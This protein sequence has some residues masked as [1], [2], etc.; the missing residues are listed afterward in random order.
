MSLT[1]LLTSAP[2]TG[3]KNPDAVLA[4]IPKSLKKLGRLARRYVPLVKPEATEE[5]AIAHDYLTQ[6]GGAERVVLAMHRAFPDAPIYTTLY[7]PEGTFPEFKD[8][9]IITS[10]LNKIG[11]LR[12]NHRMALPILPFA[13]SFLKV[14]AERAVVSTTGWAHGF[15][16]AGRKFI[17]CHSPARWLYLSDQYLGEK[18]TENVYGKKDVPIFFPP[19]SVDTTAPVEP[20]PGLEEFTESDDYFLIVSRLLPYK[21]VDKAVEACNELGK[22]LLVI[23]RGP[24]KERLEALA[25]PTIRIASGVSDAQLRYAYR[26]CLA[27]LAISYEDFGITPL[28]A[29]ASG[30]AVIAYR[31]G[32]FLDTIQEGKTGMFINQPTVE[33]LVEALK[34]FNPD[35]WDADYIREHVDGFSEARFISRL[36]TYVQ[37]LPED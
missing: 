35:D 26:H 4:D 1:Q 9:K 34:A 2:F 12:R 31:A 22:K 20:I 5:I 36:K 21:N 23:G 11:Y 19:H 18:S 24:E 25:G 27:L 15:N 10:P 6:R 17:Y 13:S 3:P 7:D 32:G 30:K 28:E 14:P 37:A 29:G 33:Q 8:A 16:F